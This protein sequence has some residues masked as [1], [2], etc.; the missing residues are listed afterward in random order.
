M[1]ELLEKNEVSICGPVL[2]E[3]LA[4]TPPDRQAELATAV[5]N[6]H[7]SE[8]DHKGWELVG[9]ISGRLREAGEPLPLTD[10]MIAVAAATNEASLWT[11]DKDFDRI[12]AVFPQLKLL[13]AAQ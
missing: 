12:A 2:A 4:G 5:G 1:T 9:S 10:L 7:W 13:E 3:L 6:L 11:T 8:I